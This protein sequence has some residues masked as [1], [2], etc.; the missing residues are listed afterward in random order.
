MSRPQDI[1]YINGI[2]ISPFDFTLDDDDVKKNLLKKKE[3]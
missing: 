2:P 1:L 3:I